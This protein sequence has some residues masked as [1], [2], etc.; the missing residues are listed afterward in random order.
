MFQRIILYE[1]LCLSV[2]H[3]HALQFVLYCFFPFFT[4]TPHTRSLTCAHKH[5][6][7]HRHCIGKTK[8]Q[9]LL[10]ISSFIML[11]TKRFY[12]HLLHFFFLFTFTLKVSHQMEVLECCEEFCVWWRYSSLKE[13]SYLLMKRLPKWH[14]ISFACSSEGGRRFIEQFLVCLPRC[15]IAGVALVFQF[16]LFSFFTAQVSL[17][18]SL[19]HFLSIITLDFGWSSQWN[20]YNLLKRILEHIYDTRC[21]LSALVE[22]AQILLHLFK[23]CSCSEYCHLLCLQQTLS[24]KTIWAAILHDQMTKRFTV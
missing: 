16:L 7:R 18:Q 5:T 8:A 14:I 11:K 3:M 4:F 21:V 2:F 15:T 24:F 12:A 19:M 13:P 20:N 23:W 1:L 10:V 22:N 9:G 6:H 17:M